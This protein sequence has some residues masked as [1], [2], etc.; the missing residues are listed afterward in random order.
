M[1]VIYWEK[2]KNGTSPELL[3][4]MGQHLRWNIPRT[5]KLKHPMRH[6]W[7]HPKGHIFIYV[8]T[9]KIIKK[10]SFH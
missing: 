3:H 9:A 1:Q 8:Y 10:S 4:Q 5:R 7:P 2:L 6:K